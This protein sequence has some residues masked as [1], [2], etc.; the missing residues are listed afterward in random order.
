MVA[1]LGRATILSWVPLGADRVFRKKAWVRNISWQFI[2]IRLNW[3]EVVVLKI[4]DKVTQQWNEVWQE[5]RA[6]D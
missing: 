4:E 3:A 2:H 6:I 5:L 1:G